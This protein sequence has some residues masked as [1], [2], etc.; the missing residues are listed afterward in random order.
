[1]TVQVG[2][3]GLG[4]MGSAMARN[5]LSH[6]LSVTGFDLSSSAMGACEHDRFRPAGSPREVAEAADIVLLSLPSASAFREV[7]TDIAQS[8]GGSRVIAD[9]STLPL[10]EKQAGRSLL[11]AANK[12]LLDCP[13]SGT[14]AQ[15]KRKDLVVFASG[16]REDYDI[17]LPALEGMSRQ[18]RY[19]GEF[20][21]GSRMKFIANLLVNIHNVAAAEAFVL[22]RKAGLDAAVLYDVI[23]D[24]AGSSRMFQVRGP[25]MVEGGYE[26]ATMTIDMWQKD[27]EIIAQFAGDLECPV[28]LFTAAAKPYTMALAQGRGKQDTAAVCAVLEHA[29]GV[30]R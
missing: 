27:L 25:M 19:L 8:R 9:T 7:V 12:G 2:M 15:A 11:A 16:E 1:M 29:I 4:I 28:A 17:C 20:G 26:P 3:V 30:Q 14:G 21:N 22:G 10:A 18:Q 6:G 13:V 5:M 23:A 24:S